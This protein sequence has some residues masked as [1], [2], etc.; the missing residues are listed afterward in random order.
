MG[1][2]SIIAACLQNVLPELVAFS[3]RPA[4]GALV[5]WDHELGRLLEKLE[6][7]GFSSPSMG[8]LLTDDLGQ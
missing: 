2:D 4:I 6:E 3:L 1:R 7:F 5:D 8:C